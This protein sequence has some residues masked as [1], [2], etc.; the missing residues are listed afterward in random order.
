MNCSTE[1][2]CEECSSLVLDRA[3]MPGR[4]SQPCVTPHPCVCL[5]IVS[6]RV[7]ECYLPYL[8]TTQ[9]SKV[10]MSETKVPVQGS[11]YSPISNRTRV[12]FLINKIFTTTMLPMKR[13]HN[14]RCQDLEKCHFY[15]FENDILALIIFTSHAYEILNGL[16]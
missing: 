8:V 13:R 12:F 1:L 3:S 16:M 15:H 2:Q 5:G 10:K 7:D 11:Q 9:G 14:H 6:G 4:L